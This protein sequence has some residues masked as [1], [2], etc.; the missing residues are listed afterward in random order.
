MLFQSLLLLFHWT[1]THHALHMRSGPHTDEFG[2]RALSCLYIGGCHPYHLALAD[3]TERALRKVDHGTIHEPDIDRGNVKRSE[4]VTDLPL[5][6]GKTHFWDWT[7]VGTFAASYLIS[8]LKKTC[9]ILF[10]TATF[11]SL[12]LSMRLVLSGS[13]A[14]FTHDIEQKL[15][16]SV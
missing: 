13:S 11:F 15:E 5:S 4:G 16:I 12:F 1:P 2:L 9:I 7:C 14:A 6:N 3:N 10:V 8:T